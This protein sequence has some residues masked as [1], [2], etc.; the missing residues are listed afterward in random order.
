[1]QSAARMALNPK[2]MITVTVEELEAIKD[3]ASLR[4][5]EMEWQLRIELAR[6][7]EVERNLARIVGEPMPMQASAPA[8]VQA[9]ASPAKGTPM[10][11]RGL[12][13]VRRSPPPP[14]RYIARA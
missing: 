9:Q 14:P 13:P 12:P 8:T 4:A 5:E 10:P 7:R 3:A 11:I 1:M 2:F 6:L